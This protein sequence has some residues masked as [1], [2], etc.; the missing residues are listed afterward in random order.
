MFVCLVKD[1]CQQVLSSGCYSL[2]FET[3]GRFKYGFIRFWKDTVLVKA[4]IC[5]FGV[6]SP[7]LVGEMCVASRVISAVSTKPQIVGCSGVPT[8]FVR[9]LDAYEGL[10]R[11]VQSPFRF[12]AISLP[13]L[14]HRQGFGLFGQLDFFA[15]LQGLIVSLGGCVHLRW[16]LSTPEL[17][18]VI[19]NLTFPFPLF[20]SF[21][22]PLGFIGS[23]FMQA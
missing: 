19:C 12:D 23:P 3:R 18:K 1:L 8:D 16:T 7:P 11:T 10:K 9:V 13:A 21:L 22:S 6:Q 14:M 4:F 17:S 2:E 5:R 15:V 20:F